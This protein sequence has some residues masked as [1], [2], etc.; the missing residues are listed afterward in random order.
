MGALG[1]GRSDDG[2]ETRSRGRTAPTFIHFATC[3][4]DDSI[5]AIV[6]RTAGSGTAF[7]HRS[8][9]YPVFARVGGSLAHLQPVGNGTAARRHLCRWRP[10]GIGR[11]YQSG[12]R[13]GDTR[14]PYRCCSVQTSISGSFHRSHL[15]RGKRCM[16]GASVLQRGR[17]TAGGRRLESDKR[18]SSRSMGGSY[19][20]SATNLASDLEPSHLVDNESD[21]A[22]ILGT[23]RPY[24]PRTYLSKSVAEYLRIERKG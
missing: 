13:F 15:W 1:N 21:M 18:E 8:S 14:N 6:V 19:V 22:T 24:R 12:S 10:T 20:E 3:R 5:G 4:G 17:F 23:V 9:L 7:G 16:L 11:C 2:R